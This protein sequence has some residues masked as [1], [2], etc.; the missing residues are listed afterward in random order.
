MALPLISTL[1]LLLF[2]AEKREE[3]SEIRPIKPNRYYAENTAVLRLKKAFYMSRSAIKS[4]ISYSI[5]GGAVVCGVRADGESFLGL[6]E[7]ARGVCKRG[8]FFEKRTASKGEAEI[9][10]FDILYDV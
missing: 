7:V 4:R 10:S 1:L 3:P 5:S 6:R 9:R 8:E 2:T